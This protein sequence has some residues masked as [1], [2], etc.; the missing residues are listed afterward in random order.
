MTMIKL[1]NVD[2]YGLFAK[3]FYLNPGQII[4]IGQRVEKRPVEA[5]Y[6]RQNPSFLY[7][8]PSRK[9]A[10]EYI[11]VTASTVEVVIQ[12]TIRTYD[13]SFNVTESV[14]EVLKLIKAAQCKK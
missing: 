2:D 9:D 8:E 6:R 12:T 11:E 7:K 4:A 3:T 1:T 13:S 10:V 14:A 5:T